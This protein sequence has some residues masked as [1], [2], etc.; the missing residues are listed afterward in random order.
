MHNYINVEHTDMWD[1]ILDRPYFPTRYVIDEEL[2]KVIPR[3]RREFNEVDSKKTEKN[4][5]TKTILVC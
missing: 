1:V 2:I 4:Y 5:N 3:T